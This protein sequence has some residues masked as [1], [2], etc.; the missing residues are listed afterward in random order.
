MYFLD[1][2]YSLSMKEVD[3]ASV[4]RIS[5]SEYVGCGDLNIQGYGRLAPGESS[6]SIDRNPS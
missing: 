5:G 2:A 3:G 4:G 6:S 1:R